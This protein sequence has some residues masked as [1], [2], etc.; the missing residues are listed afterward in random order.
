MA[1][2]TRTQALAP[3]FLTMLPGYR[4]IV[5]VIA[6]SIQAGSF[7][8][9]VNRPHFGRTPG[10]VGKVVCSQLTGRFYGVASENSHSVQ[11]HPLTFVNGKW[12]V[13]VSQSVTLHKSQIQVQ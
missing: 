2:I 5:V 12:Q 8:R 9:A 7:Q 10:L 6:N 3:D 1:T 4:A 11:A 13:I